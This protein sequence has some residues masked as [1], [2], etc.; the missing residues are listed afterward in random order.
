MIKAKKILS[1]LFAAMLLSSLNLAIAQIDHD[2]ED[3][4]TTPAVGCKY[5]G[6][7]EQSC[8]S[9]NY[10]VLRCASGE[11]SCYYNP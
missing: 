6:D 5:T 10:K 7:M 11:G 2:E 8:R 9:G 4:G 1:F 3:G